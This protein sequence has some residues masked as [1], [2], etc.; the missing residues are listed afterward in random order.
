MT[1]NLPNQE[2]IR[3]WRNGDDEAAAVI[4]ER[5]RIRL[6][7]LV[8]SKLSKKLARR[9]DAEDIVLSAYRSFFVLAQSST[10]P[11][12]DSVD[13]WPLLTTITLR[14]LAHHARFHSA[15]KRTVDHEQWDDSSLFEFVAS[16]EPSV[17]DAAM[18]C[19][20][21]ENLLGRIDETAREVA[22]LTLQGFDVVTISKKLNLN[23][24]TV[25]RAIERIVAMIPRDVVETSQSSMPRLNS[26]RMF[27]SKQVTHQ[28]CEFQ[29]TVQYD[30]FLLQQF[31]GSGAFGKVYR[32]IDRITGETVAVKFLRKECW[33]D[34]RATDAIIRESE[35]LSRL[36]HPNIL[37]IRGWGMTRS[38]GLFLVTEFLSG[39]NLLTWSEKTKPTVHQIIEVVR[40][41]GRAVAA[42]NDQG[43]I[44]G[45]VKPANVIMSCDEQ[46]ILCDFGLARLAS[47]P[48]AVPRGGTAG[49]LAP[50]QL[51]DAFG[52]V[53]I[54]SDIYGIGG[55]F[56]ALL[57]GRPP[58]MGRDLPETIAHVLSSTLPI[59]PSCLVGSPIELDSIILRALQK[60][61]HKRYETVHQMVEQLRIS[62]EIKLPDD[63]VRF[64]AS[65]ELDSKRTEL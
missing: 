5:Y 38:G 26:G 28:K 14:K 11:S 56:Y 15:E 63:V 46:P 25:R 16:R 27:S 51:C 20:E 34:G 55:L 21:I 48:D 12:S 57:T 22:V 37:R 35:I 60:E 3:R 40:R 23:E 43:I 31:V 45:D 65:D 4:F 59:A 39:G 36:N 13:L 19:D 50:E 58:M 6:I 62:D 53:T 33:N 2:L 30:R 29:P 9:V 18:M 64:I 32:A 10:R 42:S 52:P 1:S 24:R 7:S 54:R 44:H 17:E 49:F 41:V 47:E 61:P 8:R